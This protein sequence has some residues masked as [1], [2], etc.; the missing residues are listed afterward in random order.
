MK[1]GTLATLI[2][3]IA[4]VL[5]AGCAKTTTPPTTT[6]PTSPPAAAPPA[7]QLQGFAITATAADGLVPNSLIVKDGAD[8]NIRSFDNNLRITNQGLGI[9]VTIAQ[10]EAKAIKVLPQQPGTYTLTCQGCPDGK[11]TITVEVK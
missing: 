3:L 2:L 5:L 9:D 7:P 1:R 10:G 8:L 4:L 6:P 11:N